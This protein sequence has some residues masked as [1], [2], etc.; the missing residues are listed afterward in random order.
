MADHVPASESP[1][2]LADRFRVGMSAVELIVALVERFPEIETLRLLWYP[3][4]PGLAQRL[5]EQEV[6][7]NVD[8]IARQS[9]Q[10]IDSGRRWFSCGREQID[11][12]AICELAERAP[13]GKALGISSLV[14]RRD[15]S[16]AHLPMMDFDCEISA[17]NESSLLRLFRDDLRQPHGAL[18]NSGRSYH[19]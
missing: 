8:T 6:P 3:V 9:A 17:L 12:A 15:G 18:L 14:T 10:H 1:A 19:Y 2:P 5:S 4:V 13:A 11:I 7:V 16:T